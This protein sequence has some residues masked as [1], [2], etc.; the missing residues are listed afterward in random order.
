MSALDKEARGSQ[1]FA[2]MRR[3]KAACCWHV[4]LF[5]GVALSV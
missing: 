1:L 5:L 3:S 2:V 4:V